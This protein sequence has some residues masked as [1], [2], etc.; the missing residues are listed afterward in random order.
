[1]SSSKAARETRVREF[2]DITGAS[3]QEAARFLKTTSYRLDAALEAFFNDP[4]AVRA[5][6][7]QQLSGGEGGTSMRNL[8]RLWD[9]YRD[10]EKPDEIHFEGTLRYCE[11]LGITPDDIVMLAVAWLTKAPTMGHFF[12][13]GW[14]DGWREARR[15]TI[16]LQRSY[17]DRLRTDLLKGDTFRK[18]YAFT[19]DYAKAE[20]QKSMR[21]SIL[22]ATLG[23][24][25]SSRL[26]ADALPYRKCAEFE[27]A[28]ELWKLLIP[29]DPA[30]DFP[31]WHLLLWLEFLETRGARPVSKDTWNLV[32]LTKSVAA[33]SSTRVLLAASAHIRPARGAGTTPAQT[34]VDIDARWHIQFLDFTRTIDPLFQEHDEEGEAK[35]AI[36]Y[37]VS[38][39]LTGWRVTLPAAWPSVIDDFV[40]FARQSMAGKH[41]SA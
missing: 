23:I 35:Y 22:S 26:P 36:L 40:E 2:I 34:N 38:G 13:K 8:D 4:T 24:R 31:M 14:I 19:F 6:E 37:Y 39:T 11:D 27:I 17:I 3:P 16:K 18:V 7:Q 33:A 5:A 25:A 15:D 12:K 9:K 30:A 28:Q 20:G 10:A 29:A 41:E 32:R 1:M 21:P